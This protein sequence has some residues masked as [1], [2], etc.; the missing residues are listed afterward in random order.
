MLATSR[1]ELRVWTAGD[2]DLAMALWGDPDVTRFIGG[3]F[4]EEQVRQRLSREIANQ[5]RYGVQYWPLVLR[6][7][8]EPVGC[9]GLAPFQP[10]ERIY[11]L[12]FHLR[13]EHW[14]RGYA[15][16]AAVAVID[17][18]FGTLGAKGLFAGH[19]PENEASRRLLAKLGFRY[20]HDQ[21][22]PPTGRLHPSYLLMR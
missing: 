6:T 2:F 22:Y 4:S 16:E 18:A 19:H 17:F 14:G 10:D 5:E 1:L 3:P 8:G 20:T 7:T 15:Q 9:C 12:G 13:K 11:E 21:L